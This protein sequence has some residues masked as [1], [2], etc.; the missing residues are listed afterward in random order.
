MANATATNTRIFMGTS[1]CVWAAPIIRR[2]RRY[3]GAPYAK[4]TAILL[5]LVVVTSAC[6]PFERDTSGHDDLRTQGLRNLEKIAA[7]ER[8]YDLY[9]LG[10]GFTAGGIEYWGPDVDD[11]D[12]DTAA[13]GEVRGGGLG[14]YY[15]PS[16]TTCCGDL[17]LV[18]YSRPAWEMLQDRR[19]RG[20]Q[21]RFESKEVEVN[22]QPAELRTVF[23]NPDPGIAA[24]V[25]VVDYGGTVVYAVTGSTNSSTATAPDTNPLIDEEAFLAVMQNLRPYPE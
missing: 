24:R 17:N 22:G 15:L 12:S 1:L 6:G 4:I 21:P 11:P 23:N 16:S 14:M 5:P 10:P 19:R 20:A 25:L 2:L 3:I 7:S 8:N 13:I 18:L 9:W